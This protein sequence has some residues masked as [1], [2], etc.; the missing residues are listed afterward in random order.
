MSSISDT[1][2]RIPRKMPYKKRNNY[3][4]DGDGEVVQK[5][6][7]NP[8][9][10][11]VTAEYI[12][13][14]IYKITNLKLKIKT[15]YPYQLAFVHKSVYKKNIAPVGEKELVFYQTYESLEFVGDAWVGAIVADYLYHR[16]PGQDEGYLTKLRT[17]IVCSKQMAK[18]SEYLGLSEYVIITPRIEKA[19]GRNH[20]KIMEDI[21]EALCAAIKQDLGI[22]VLEIFVKNLIEAT[23]NFTNIILYDDDY[24]TMLLQYFQKHGWPHP[25]YTTISHEGA[26]H[27]RVFTVG[28][29]YIDSFERYQLSA[30]LMEYVDSKNGTVQGRFL[31]TAKGKIKKDAE[32]LASKDALKTFGILP[33]DY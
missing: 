4:R 7:Y 8:K 25:T 30:I 12:E 29:D 9:N 26:G 2:K 10:K 11:L 19:I 27:K 1:R 13:D 5:N 22:P 31:T 21:F 24:K 32:Q 23:V 18:Y 17:K 15:L 33:E 28:L 6:F 20:M 3:R 14:L 16:F